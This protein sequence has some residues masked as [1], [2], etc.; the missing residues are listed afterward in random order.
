MYYITS[1]ATGASTVSTPTPREIFVEH[2]VSQNRNTVSSIVG[3]TTV[4]VGQTYNYTV[5]GSTAP[6]GYEQLE[7]F[8]SLSN[9]IF[10]VLSVNTTYTQP[11][12]ATNDKIYAD[13]CGW[14]NNP[15]SLTYRSCTTTGK[16]GGTIKTDYTVLVLSA[17][18][19]TAS[20]LIYDF[21]GSSYHYN[22]DFG[23]GISSITITA[24]PNGSIS[25][26][27]L[28]DVN[29]LTD[30]IV[31][32]TGTNAG[33]PLYANLLDANNVVVQ[34]I[35]LPANGAYSFSGLNNGN[36]TVQVST[37]QGIVG[38]A[39]P[40]T[41]LPTGWVNTG[42]F[43]GTGVGNDGTVNG[44]LPVS[45]GTTATSITGANF[46]IEQ[47]PTANNN[48]ATSQTNPGGT[49]SAVVPAAT[50]SASDLSGGTVSNIRITAFPTNATSLIVGTTT[51]YANTGAI[52]TTCPTATCAAFPAGGVTIATSSNGNPTT[53]IS[54]DPING[55]VTVGFTYVA[56]DNA[57][58]ESAT[59]ATASVPFA[60]VSISGAVFNDANGLTDN[61]VN[62]T[63]PN[64]GATLYANL[65]DASG[66]VLQS[67]TVST[68]TGLYNFAN[69]DSG[70]YTIQISTNQG[71]VG[72]AAP[73]LAL[74]ANWVN[75]GEFV[76]TGVGNDGAVNGLLPVNV[77]AAVGNANFG[78]EQRPVANT[79]T[80]ANQTNPGG[81]NN[82]AVPA[83]TF[84]AT[85]GAPGT[86]ANV[87][88]TAFPSNATS[89]TINGT[90]YTAA[91]FPSGG[92]TVPTNASGNP[93]QTILVDPV[94]GAMT[95]AFSY[96]ALDN[97][98]VASASPATASVPF[99]LA[100]TAS[101]VT[102]GGRVTTAT[103]RGI[104]RARVTLTDSNGS[105]RVAATNAFGYYRFVDV[106]AGETFV[107][108]VKDK[109]YVF[110]NPAQV[111]SVNE[112][113]T[114][115]N[116][117]ARGEESKQDKSG[118]A[119]FDFDGDGKTDVAVYRPS[120]QTW[121][122]LQSASGTLRA[123]QF[124]VDAGDK[125]AP[126]DYD[127][128][129]KTDLAV[130]NAESKIWTIL[131]S[132]NGETQRIVVGFGE[133]NAGVPVAADYDG[134]GKADIA[135]D[136]GGADL[137]IKQSSN[138]EFVR[139]ESKS[140]VRENRTASENSS[141]IILRGDFD[142]DGLADAAT[143][144][145]GVWTITNSVGL[146]ENQ[147]SFGLEGDIP[148]PSAYLPKIVRSKKAETLK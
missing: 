14:D 15:S 16:A 106:A 24:L 8:L 43:V 134:D 147:I 86:V 133:I 32:G 10:K 136:F 42:E 29:G 90:Q 85:D 26:T 13:S 67:A 55:A 23:T 142:G 74:P 79:N 56:I 95:V 60:I 22:S 141:A 96:V 112:D 36:Y 72:S 33:G 113:R 66:V 61:T 107:M 17:G 140:I 39:A 103:G 92:V 110:D 53:A 104:Y 68:A 111:M 75:T 88:I 128:D 99:V 45:I 49:N 37:N 47:R 148:A 114:D 21:S 2:L 63:V 12:G 137:E 34:T 145:K 71:T 122:I 41:A 146:Q 52:P 83:T 129:G 77:A 105:G 9:V 64:T 19:T 91:S 87:R 70:S 125:I 57:N 89:I 4:Y 98:G 3:P 7:A 116:F 27:V 62:G 51:Y 131:Q 121:Y 48:T 82:V 115:I 117:I 108:S 25:G 100:P 65:L 127:G 135:L 120:N 76:G 6:G 123:E 78:I 124:P 18:T 101:E 94:D 130:Y 84:S 109:R 138:G 132:S 69:L 144:D 93:T 81:T 73:A 38:N 119:P 54:V 44:L 28:N 102:V 58:V 139:R 35:L 11:V 30:S 31:N 1:S 80:A 50:F 5:N 20:T 40:A 46:G 118:S 97:A 126:A 59:P 143:F